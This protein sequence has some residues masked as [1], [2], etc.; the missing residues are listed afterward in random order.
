MPAALSLLVAEKHSSFASFTFLKGKTHP[1]AD[2]LF[3][4]ILYLIA[5]WFPEL[6]LEQAAWML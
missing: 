4:Y 1:H 3:D 5:F 2:G 6:G